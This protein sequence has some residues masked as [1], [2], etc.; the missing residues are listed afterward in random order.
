M[1][2]NVVMAVIVVLVLM[3]GGIVL[4]RPKQ[5]NPSQTPSVQTPAS[6][7]SASP[8]S[9]T[10]GAIVKEETI[11]KITSTG[12][13]PKVITIKAGESVTWMNEDSADHQ[14]LSAIHPTHTVYPPLNTIGLLKSG[15]KK[16]LSFPE[17]ETY[18]YHDHLNPSL[19]GS[20]T[21]Q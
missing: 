19:T 6:T 14:V 13:S 5:P 2:R 12:F 9:A 18:K 16:S 17:A 15:E 11:V 20:V 8:I 4:T 3:V 7:E 10:E 21:V 1:S